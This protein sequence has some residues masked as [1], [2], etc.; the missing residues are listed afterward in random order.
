[1]YGQDQLSSILPRADYIVSVLPNTPDTHHI[2]STPEFEQMKDGVFIANLGRGI[3]IDE[4]ALIS[5]LRSGKVRGAGLDTFETEPLPETSLLW[6]FENVI[7]SPHCA[8]FQPDYT[9]EARRLFID[10]LKR[11]MAGEKLFNVV[12]KSLGYSLT[13]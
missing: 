9:F 5:G 6:D 7:I 12:D 4:E 10:N 3:H 1:M 8:G 2:L 13:H 11:F